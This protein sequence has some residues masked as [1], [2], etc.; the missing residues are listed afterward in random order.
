MSGT[1][2]P[3]SEPVMFRRTAMHALVGEKPS[4]WIS[5]IRLNLALRSEKRFLRVARFSRSSTSSSRIQPGRSRPHL[6]HQLHHPP[7]HWTLSI[8]IRDPIGLLTQ[9]T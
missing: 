2:R 7:D 6:A 8:A 5:I 4:T 1:A 9:H 3:Y